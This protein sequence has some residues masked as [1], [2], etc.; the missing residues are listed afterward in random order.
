MNRDLAKE[1]ETTNH[2]SYKSAVHPLPEID[3]YK[4]LFSFYISLSMVFPGSLEKSG[5]LCCRNNYLNY[6][7]KYVY[8][9]FT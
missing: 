7:N 1:G 9:D 5:E 4:V 8:S 2:W 3:H 6:L